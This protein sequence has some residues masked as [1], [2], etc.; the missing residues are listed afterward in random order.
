MAQRWRRDQTAQKGIQAKRV[1]SW[2]W[3]HTAGGLCDSVSFNRFE[4]RLEQHV[5][6]LIFLVCGRGGEMCAHNTSKDSICLFLL[7]LPLDMSTH[8]SFL[9]QPISSIHCCAGCGLY[10]PI[11][12]SSHAGVI[13]LMQGRDNE[14][15]KRVVDCWREKRQWKREQGG[16]V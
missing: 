7:K 9:F 10:V 2:Y 6:S 13:R 14:M 16:R 5:W 1:H 12:L 8:A 15:Q 11:I 3:R 4:A